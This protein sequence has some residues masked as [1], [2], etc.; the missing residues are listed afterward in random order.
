MTKTEQPRHFLSLRIFASIITVYLGISYGFFAFG[1]DNFSYRNYNFLSQQFTII[2][3]P[4]MELFASGKVTH[5]YDWE[6]IKIS[7]IDVS[8]EPV[9][10]RS[11][12]Q[13]YGE[14]SKEFSYKNTLKSL[15]WVKEM[16]V[17]EPINFKGNWSYVFCSVKENI[18]QKS[19]ILT[20][21]PVKVLNDGEVIAWG[22]DSEG[23]YLQLRLL[24][25]TQRDKNKDILF[26]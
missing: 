5:W 23:K 18:C 9:S 7:E 8:V 26:I 15:G 13:Q 1:V 4:F 20:K 19:N 12:E 2:S 21:G 25:Y 22:Q 10:M 3:Q 24:G 16:A 14:Y 11:E 17:I 6:V